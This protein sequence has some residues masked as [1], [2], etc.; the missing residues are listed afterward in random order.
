[1]SGRASDSGLGSLAASDCAARDS[2]QMT[3]RR[4]DRLIEVQAVLAPDLIKLDVEA[5]STRC[6]RDSVVF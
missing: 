4:G 5:S 3:A 1:M 6:W 2:V